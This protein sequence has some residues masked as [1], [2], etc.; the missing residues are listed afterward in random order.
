MESE[1]KHIPLSLKDQKL[2]DNA[3]KLI[4]EHLDDES[5]GVDELRKA[6]GLSRSQLHRRLQKTT[7]LSTSLFIRTVR[8]SKAFELLTEGNLSVSEVAYRTGF[9]SPSYFNKCFHEQYGF[10]PGDIHKQEILEIDKR[11]IF[12]GLK[13]PYIKEGK[14]GIDGKKKLYLYGVLIVLIIIFAA[15][16]FVAK[17]S[18]DK[19]EIRDKSIAV[20][21]FKNFSDNQDNQYI[22]DG[23]MEAITSN[24]S[25]IG[26]L[27]VISRTSMEQYRQSPKSVR[28]IGAELKVGYLLEGSTFRDE[29]NVRVTV[30]LIDTQTDE[31]I[32]SD[33]YDFELRN[34]F[35][36]QSQIAGEIATVLQTKITPEERSRLEQ[37]PT[38]S[39]EA[40]DLYQRAFYYFI[41]YLQ[42][43]QGTDYS[44]AWTLFS[45]AIKEDSTFAAA[46][47]RLADL[48]WMMNYR[49]EYYKDT[50]M[51]TVFWLCRK[52]LSFDPQSSDGHRLL[53]QYFFETGKREQGI[54]ELETA[55][56]LNRNNA[57]VYDALG[58]YYNWFG[59]WE[60]GIPAL[61]TSIE[62][63]PYSVLLPVRYGNLAR[64]YLDI[65]D[66]EK[67]FYY[68]QKAIELSEGREPSLRFAYWV[69]A[70]T[71]LMLGDGEKA[72]DATNKLAEFNEIMALRIQAEVYCHLFQD[73]KKGIDLY[74]ELSRKDPEHYNYKHRYAYA[75]WEVGEYD[76]A[77][78]MFDSQIRAFEKELEL[79]R[80]ERNDPHY[81]LAAI[82]TFF[83]DYD[84]AF[85]H[86]RAHKFT[87]GLEMYAK[88]DPLFKDL[89]DNAEFKQ[90]IQDAIDEKDLVRANIAAKI[91]EG[92]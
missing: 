47:L 37:K 87:S 18:H 88:I 81:N 45:K 14:R 60:T 66:F 50:F 82:Y 4:T 55:I 40:Y 64:G 90:I 7:N 48:Y 70:H 84:K 38:V 39:P 26:D 2:L 24:I 32:W 73:F 15:I 53:G 61:Y 33:S 49:R 86:L 69:N 23:M 20:L 54:S 36:V 16:F 43:R 3:V 65:L 71:H 78:V 9:S 1:S 76:S 5:F 46:Y 74:K 85:E 21:P 75:L 57:S 28:Q 19:I 89:Y 72:L 17:D 34:I 44:S 62:L 59:R 22:S 41:N 51:D 25:K 8:L 31:H 56:S 27:K 35:E 10:P 6:L 42:H 80:V 92:Y 79:G 58:F 63:D 83:G 12:D 67:T 11:F 77:K 29:D 30:Q 68:S 52:G 13:S 91:T